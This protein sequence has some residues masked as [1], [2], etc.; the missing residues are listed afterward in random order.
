VDLDLAKVLD[1]KVDKVDLVDTG[2]AGANLDLDLDR[3]GPS[4]LGWGL[5]RKPELA[6]TG[7]VDVGNL[8]DKKKKEKKRKKKKK[9]TGLFAPPLKKK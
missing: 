8:L 7:R 5:D 4:S 1:H 3:A 6:Q 2:L 9:K